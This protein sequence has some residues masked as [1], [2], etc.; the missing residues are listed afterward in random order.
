[1]PESI[2]QP[3]GWIA[4]AAFVIG[5]LVRGIKSDVMS[6]ALAKLGLPPIPSRAL[7]W[8][9]LG[10]GALAA[11]LDAKVAGSTWEGAAQSGITA[12]ALAVL[13]HEL[14]SGVPGVKKILSFAVV[15]GF[16]ANLSACAWWQKHGPTLVDLLAEKTKCA[17]ARMDLSDE[18]IIRECAI[19]SDDVPRILELVSTARDEAA[20][21]VSV[22]VA[23]ERHRV[24]ASTCADAGA[25]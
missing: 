3:I 11:V 4:L 21:Q 22:A 24:S 19:T 23:V 7:P 1:M 25:P 13:G 9:A 6:I 17:L 2:P 12:T 8:L 5:L 20:R 14:G 10:L 15:I 18:I 16:A